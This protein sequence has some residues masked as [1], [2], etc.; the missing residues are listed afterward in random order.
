VDNGPGEKKQ[1]GIGGLFSLVIHVR[2]TTESAV[3][4]RSGT[5]RGSEWF[6]DPKGLKFKTR[7]PL[8]PGG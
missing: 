4:R 2:G 1:N 7:Q 5:P 8:S 6:T 3:S